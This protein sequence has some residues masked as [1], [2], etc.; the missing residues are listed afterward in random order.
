LIHPKSVSHG[1]ENFAIR[2]PARELAV[3]VLQV[4]VAGKQQAALDFLG[5]RVG[6][7]T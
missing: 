6:L 3:H 1:F 5:E 2:R 4:D 7:E